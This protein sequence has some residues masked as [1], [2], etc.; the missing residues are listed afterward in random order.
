MLWLHPKEVLL[1]GVALDGVSSVAVDRIAARTAEEHGDLGPHV[2]FVDA[3]EQR[4]IVKIRRCVDAVSAGVLSGIAV[5]AMG[6][7]SLRVAPLTS[8]R[9]ARRITAMVVVR[10]VN[11]DFTERDG[12]VQS[13]SMTAVS[14]DGATDPIAEVEEGS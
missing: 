4:V 6:E 11:H 12:L 2:V 10:S 1:F 7:L 9:I 5:G 13:I 3:P 14:S 8:D